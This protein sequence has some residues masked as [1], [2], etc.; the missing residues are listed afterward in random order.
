ML[1][2]HG[3]GSIDGTWRIHRGRSEFSGTFT[4][5]I[6]AESIHSLSPYRGWADRQAESF[7]YTWAPSRCYS[8][9]HTLPCKGRLS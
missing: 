2:A 7:T 3:G 4:C 5:G 8:G 6:D 1:E 9:F